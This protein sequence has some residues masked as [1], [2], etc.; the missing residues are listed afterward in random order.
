MNMQEGSLSY[1]KTP[2]APKPPN[3]CA[4]ACASAKASATRGQRRRKGEFATRSPRLS[5]CPIIIGVSKMMSRE[6]GMLW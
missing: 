2:G 1:I 4:K 5:K 3:A 6:T